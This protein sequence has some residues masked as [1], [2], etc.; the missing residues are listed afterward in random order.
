MSDTIIYS[1]ILRSLDIISIQSIPIIMLYY[2][3]YALPIIIAILSYLLC[4][5]T[6]QDKIISRLHFSFCCNFFHFMFNI[7]ISFHFIPI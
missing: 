6:G 4:S 2:V 1:F 7:S 5:R 3:C